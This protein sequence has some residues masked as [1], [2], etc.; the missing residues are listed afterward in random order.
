[1]TATSSSSSTWQPLLRAGQLPTHP[2]NS[3][4]SS[5]SATSSN[6]VPKRT[7][8]RTHAGGQVKPET[9]SRTTPVPLPAIAR[10]SRFGTSQS[11]PTTSKRSTSI[12]SQPPPQTSTSRAPSTAM[13]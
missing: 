6:D 10:L 3:E 2:A 7:S 11:A 1:V 5:A 12:R 9:V 13:R 4:L 8:S